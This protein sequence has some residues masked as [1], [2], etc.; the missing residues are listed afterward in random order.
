MLKRSS[1]LFVFV[2]LAVSL[3][4]QVALAHKMSVFAHVDGQQIQGEVVA[5]GHDLMSGMKIAAYGP[6]GDT[7]A[8]TVTDDKG[9]F[10]LTVTRRC[11]WKI[12]ASGGGHLASC[13]VLAGELPPNLPAEQPDAHDHE[14]PHDEATM[15]DHGHSHTGELEEPN[16]EDE[17]LRRQ[18]IALREDIEKLRDKL[19]W[20]DIV[21]G[22]GYILGLMG[23]TFYFLG[24]RRGERFPSK[25]GD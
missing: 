5:E 3:S 20:Q 18:V 8:E 9:Q 24:S 23:V 6:S 7:L 14:H 17:A 19:R 11:D 2:M 22:V 16:G 13:V 25:S 10:T 12:V 1:L 4:A 21:G 15:H